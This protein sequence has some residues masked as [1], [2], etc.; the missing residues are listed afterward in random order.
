MGQVDKGLI[1]NTVAHHTGSANIHCGGP[2][3]IWT[4]DSNN[5]TIQFCESYSNSSGT[6]CDG[7]GFD[8]DGGVTNSLMQYNYSHDNDGAGYLLGQYD[9]ARPWSN[10]VVRYNISENDG[11]TNAGGITLFKGAGTTMNGVKIYNNTVYTSPSAANPAMAA[12]R[13]LQWN[14]GITGAEVYNNIFQ[15]TGGASLVDIPSGYS[16]YFAGNLYWSS[17]GA[18]KIKYQG[19]TYS[20]L[21]TWRTATGNEK[22]GSLTTGIVADPMLMGAGSGITVY[23]NATSQLASYKF[24]GASPAIDAGLNLATLFSINVGT[25]DYF[26]NA[27][28]FGAA[29]DIGA[30]EHHAGVSTGIS[31]G[32]LTDGIESVIDVFPNPVKI[33]DQLNVRVSGAKGPYSIE[34]ISLT[35]AVVWK[36]TKI[37]A[38]VYRIPTLNVASAIYLI[39]V[40]EDEGKKQ[41]VKKIMLE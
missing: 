28:P 21:T 41:T 26:G 37:E 25:R 5:I 1:E 31:L 35:G 9:N 11:K 30:C 4:W 40:T 22:S 20:N 33:G 8:L 38:P 32:G 39:S 34:V 7:L 27:A 36:Q 12:F 10:N 23:P 6:G 29:S 2:G 3:G 15:T 16:A 13:I 14:T 24:A 17:G 18:F 19:T